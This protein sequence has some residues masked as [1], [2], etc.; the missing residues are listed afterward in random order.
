MKTRRENTNNFSKIDSLKFA[1]ACA[2]TVGLI[3]LIL[4]LLAT[5]FGFWQILDYVAVLYYGYE[6]TLAGTLIG[7][8]CGFVQAF[9]P[10]YL[11]AVIYNKSLES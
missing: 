11:I 8:A 9:V 2:Y 4:G 7:S 3:V 6:P 1:F 10:A 5:F